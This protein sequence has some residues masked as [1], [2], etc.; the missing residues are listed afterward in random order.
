MGKKLKKPEADIKKAYETIKNAKIKY[1]TYQKTCFHVHTPAS[2][3]YKLV[4]N[5]SKEQ[6]K[7]ASDNEVYN[8]C[9]E[10]RVFPREIELESLEYPEKYESCKEWLSYLLLANALIENEIK[11]VTVTDHNTIC[12][13]D[14]LK[15]AIQSIKQY[16]VG[17]YP[18]VIMGIEISCADKNHVVGLF[19]DDEQ[20]R[21]KIESWIDEN[22]I[23][24]EE[25]TFKS[26]LEVLDFINEIGGVAYVAH[27]NS[28]YIFT[29]NYLSGA[30]K[31]KLLTKQNIVGISS[32]ESMDATLSRIS[33]FNRDVKFILDND[34]HTIDEVK[35]K[36]FWIKGRKCTFKAIQEALADY[37]I[38]ISLSYIPEPTTYIEGIYI[39]NREEGFLFGQSQEAF[40][41]RFSPALNCLI[42]GRGTGKSTILE[43]M[44]YVLSQ[45]CTSKKKLEFIC[46]HGNVWILYQHSGDEY[47]VELRTPET[48]T[49]DILTHFGQN[50]ENKYGYRYYYNPEEIRWIT[51]QRNVSVY[52]VVHI[53]NA[54][55]IELITKKGGRLKKL[56][57][58]RYSVNELVNTAGSEDIT[59]FI[60]DIMF[61]NETIS[62]PRNAVKARTVSGLKRMVKD[63]TDIMEK[64]KQEVFGII[65]SFN[66]H[67]S[68]VLRI[69]YSQN[70]A[71][72]EPPVLEWLA[73]SQHKK[74]WFNYKNLEMKKIEDYLLALYFKIGLWDF[75]RMVV[76]LDSDTAGKYENI[77]EYC[78]PMSQA[79]I[80]DNI[81]KLDENEC[82]NI[83][84]EIFSS[85]ITPNNVE[86]ILEYVSKFIS[87]SEQFTLEFNINN[88]EGENLPAHFKPVGELSLGQKVVAML[89]FILGYSDF[90]GDYR[91]LIID[92]PEDN[93]DNQ[94]I[95][96]NL[97]KQLRNIKEKR[98]IIIATHNATIVTNAKA[99]QI[100]VMKSNDK[101]GWIETTGYP[102]EK[103]IKKHIINY[104]EG[105]KES[106]LHK[107]SIYKEALQ[108]D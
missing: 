79:M 40:V 65:Q 6:Y 58:T 45:R 76:N 60:Y 39:E 92:Q 101:H 19:E 34:A 20:T 38:A 18:E 68:G 43:V 98:Q 31:Q 48:D 44:E 67:Q 75:L 71:Y 88:K 91:P 25:G 50:P 1:G 84:K 26:S 8:L 2:Y 103:R 85:L 80:E 100:C 23:H 28:S 99:D 21:R 5:W 4:S 56:Y 7:C 70:K 47:L 42:G 94:Y 83:I 77:L 15:S 52:K 64:R 78:T 36:N 66:N 74:K 59:K 90:S 82:D 104:L 11:I 102:G 69:N 62:D 14:K 3:D 46:K 87:N 12:G 107:M 35:E 63:I 53:D 37:D 72:I 51:L 24:I 105:G 29:K 10:N 9:L 17:V 89:A 54:W 55:R 81:T 13:V 49:E 57:D 86:Q 16:K 27:I 30:Y 93:L 32:L 96:K 106:F 97:V 22:L 108:E 61:C 41:M 95:Y 73:D 33:P